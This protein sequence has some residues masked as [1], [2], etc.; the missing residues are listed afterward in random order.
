[1]TNGVHTLGVASN[2]LSAS[3]TQVN[4]ALRQMDG[5]F[6]LVDVDHHFIIM[7]PK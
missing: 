4:Y 7:G 1:M 5:A 2:I 6:G 3:T